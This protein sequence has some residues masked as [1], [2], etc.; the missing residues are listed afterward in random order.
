MARIELVPEILED[1]DRIF[2]HL[3]QHWA[4]DIPGRIEEIVAGL[5]ILERH[6]EIG[7]PVE[8]GL[9]ELVLGKDSRGY[10]ALY[11]YVAPA[12]TVVVLAIR[13]QR[14]AGYARP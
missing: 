7:R 3:A 12:D 14:G 8:S 5:D 10:L 2:D 11:R 6:P 4:S 13:S 1:F 9:R